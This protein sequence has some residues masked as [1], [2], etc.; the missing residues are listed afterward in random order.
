MKVAE[1][2]VRRL[3]YGK[4]ASR[5]LVVGSANLD[6]SPLMEFLLKGASAGKDM[7]IE[8]AGLSAAEGLEMS[9]RAYSFL[10]D[11]GFDVRE[12]AKFRSRKLSDTMAANF[13]LL[14]VTS[15]AV[16]GFLLFLYPDAVIY[17][18]SEYALIGS[19]VGEIANT[20][21]SEYIGICNELSEMARR[22]VARALKNTTF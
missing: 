2:I 7:V 3:V 21:D 4:P 22:I 1:N 8:S 19:D 5:I 6:A 11:H 17:T 13:Q 12:L 14:L 10:A 18:F 15:M 20:T 9:R 16:K